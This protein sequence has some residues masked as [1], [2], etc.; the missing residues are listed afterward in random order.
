MGYAATDGQPTMCHTLLATHCY[1]PMGPLT[2]LAA[3]NEFDNGFLC[4]PYVEAHCGPPAEAH[5]G[6][7]AGAHFG[8]NAK[9]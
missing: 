8:P 3:Q 4:G 7:S 2:K 5:C 1:S 6:P 9:V